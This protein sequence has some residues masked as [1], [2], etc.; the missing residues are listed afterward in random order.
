MKT[1]PHIRCTG[2][3]SQ[4]GGFTLILALILLMV[5]TLVV[6][7]QVR[8][9]TTD[10]RLA[11]NLRE[12]VVLDQSTDTVLRWCEGMVVSTYR[13]GGTLNVISTPAGSKPAWINSANFS[14]SSAYFYS[15]PDTLAG[16]HISSEGCLIEALPI[17]A[18]SVDS[19]ELPGGNSG[20]GVLRFRITA[21]VVF[22]ADTP[23]LV[24]AS[25]TDLLQSELRLVF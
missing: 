1:H 4:Q 10:Q 24:A 2:R 25:H 13:G 21:R 17:A 12:Q 14:S 3:Q 9:S 18:A 20:A 6:V 7:F 8:R 15:Y 23:A 11:A 16:D 19:S 5:I 22:D